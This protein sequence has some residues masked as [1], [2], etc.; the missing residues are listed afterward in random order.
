[1]G[2]I[3]QVNFRLHPLEV[4][5]QTWT[6]IAP[7]PSH[8]EAP[9]RALMNA[10]MTPSCVQL[11]ASNQECALDVHIASLPECLDE[12]AARLFHIFAH[13]D[14]SES[15]DP[16]WQARQQVFDHQ[17]AIVLKVTLLPS[18]ICP[19][20]LELTEQ[21]STLGT[22]IAIVSQATGIMSIA[23]RFAPGSE[24]AP[25]IALIERLRAR[26]H[27]TGG[28]VVAL[29]IPD[30]LRGSLDVWGADPSALLLM[31]EIKRRF[32]PNRILN[33]GRFVGSI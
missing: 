18:E 15:E 4:H 31:R 28:S 22:K 20:S 12:N 25:I 3:A 27:G 1:L 5:A 14:R 33:P 24:S 17:D 29:Q 21:A 11:R 19:V 7:D 30:S 32:D 6:A 9:L 2:V 23:L 13:I 8:F 26:L 10:Q 16:V